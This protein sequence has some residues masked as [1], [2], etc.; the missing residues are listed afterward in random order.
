[1]KKITVTFK[2]DASDSDKQDLFDSGLVKDFQQLD[3]TDTLKFLIGDIESDEVQGKI[4][5]FECVEAV[6]DVAVRHLI[7][8]VNLKK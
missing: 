2:S 7:T 5:K 4:L 8:P 3:L 6:E 1:M